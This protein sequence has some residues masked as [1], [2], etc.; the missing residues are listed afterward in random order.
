MI[1]KFFIFVFLFSLHLKSCVDFFVSKAFTQLKD[2]FFHMI[3]KRRSSGEEVNEK[4]T[5]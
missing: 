1:E 4:T 2:N 3:L 5:K